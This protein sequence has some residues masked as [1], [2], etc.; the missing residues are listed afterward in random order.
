VI[1]LV[2]VALVQWT[3]SRSQNA[4]VVSAA[5]RE[6]LSQEGASQ[7]QQANVPLHTGSVSPHESNASSAPPVAIT[8]FPDSGQID[9]A[10][11]GIHPLPGPLALPT[12]PSPD[13]VAVGKGKAVVGITTDVVNQSTTAAF[14]VL[15]ANFTPGES[16]QVLLNGVLAATFTAD[17]NGRTATG[18]RCAH[19]VDS[20]GRR[21]GAG[22]GRA[23]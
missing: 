22:S 12:N 4:S 17:A 18:W 23:G 2:I 20:A 8:P 9:M 19:P 6:F 13:G 3:D 1:G 21:L 10:A 5:S 11:L 7:L 16:V 14:G 15:A